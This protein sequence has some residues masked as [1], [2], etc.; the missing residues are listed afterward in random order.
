MDAV[1]IIVMI[2]Y[3]ALV[4]GLL[5]IAAIHLTKHPDENSGKLGTTRGLG[6][7][8]LG[9]IALKTR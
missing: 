8:A 3:L 5:I 9:T 7:A 6:V 4:W 1:T 2:L